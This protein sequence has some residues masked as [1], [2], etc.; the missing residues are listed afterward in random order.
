MSHQQALRHNHYILVCISCPA[1]YRMRHSHVS[2]TSVATPQVYLSVY[3]WIAPLPT[4]ERGDSH[5]L[6]LK[7]FDKAH[8]RHNI[9]SHLMCD[10]CAGQGEH[11]VRERYSIYPPILEEA[12]SRQ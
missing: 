9:A 3:Q 8:H 4:T 2:S 1:C 11:K 6:P 5:A 12:E 7:K 10:H